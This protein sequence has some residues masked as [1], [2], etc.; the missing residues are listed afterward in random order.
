ML[1]VRKDPAQKNYKQWCHST[2][3]RF[4]GCSR[5]NGSYS[6]AASFLTTTTLAVPGIIDCDDSGDDMLEGWLHYINVNCRYHS[7]CIIGL[8]TF[9]VVCQ[10][11]LQIN[12]RQETAC[13]NSEGEPPPRILSI[14]VSIIVPQ[15]GQSRDR[16][17]SI[18]RLSPAPKWRY[19]LVW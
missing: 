14:F 12:P 13:N 16:E 19:E 8:E 15:E 7:F 1:L 3:L 6:T 17:E 4:D 5:Y 11:V 18:I 9:D 2:V 10:Q